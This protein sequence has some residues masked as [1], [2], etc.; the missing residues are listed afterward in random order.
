M[1]SLGWTYSLSIYMNFKLWE[2]KKYYFYKAIFLDENILMHSSFRDH[3][4]LGSWGSKFFLFFKEK[5]T[6]KYYFF[7]KTLYPWNPQKVAQNK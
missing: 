1:G 6:P 5:M 4:L 7:G 3:F 2:Q